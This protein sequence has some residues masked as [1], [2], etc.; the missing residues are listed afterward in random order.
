LVCPYSEDDENG[1]LRRIFENGGRGG[2]TVE[3]RNLHSTKL[4]NLSAL[5]DVI[6]VTKSGRV[7][8]V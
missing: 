6:S 5:P 7:K 4:C 1:V 8:W 2:G 3:G